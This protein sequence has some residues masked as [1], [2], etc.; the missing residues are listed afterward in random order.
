M[1]HHNAAGRFE[2]VAPSEAQTRLKEIARVL[3]LKEKNHAEYLKRHEEE[4]AALK[5]EQADLEAV[6]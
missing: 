5:K 1:K 3:A 6:A 2:P 4:T